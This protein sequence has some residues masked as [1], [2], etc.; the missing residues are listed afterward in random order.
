MAILAKGALMLFSNNAFSNDNDNMSGNLFSNELFP[1]TLPSKQM[2]ETHNTIQAKTT[3]E[4]SSHTIHDAFVELYSEDINFIMR[5]LHSRGS[6]WLISSNFNAISI[7]TKLA[8]DILMKYRYPHVDP[9]Y[10]QQCL[11]NNLHR[12]FLIINEQNDILIH[13]VRSVKEFL[14]KKSA[15][16]SMKVIVINNAETL[17]QSASS[18]IL[19]S[20]EDILG[21]VTIILL[22]KNQYEIPDTIRSR[23][24]KLSL[25][26]PQYD[27]ALA[28]CRK[29]NMFSSCTPDNTKM[30]L[31]SVQLCLESAFT[32]NSNQS[33]IAAM[34]NLFLFLHNPQS[35]EMKLVVDE[36]IKN[37]IPFDY[38]SNI[39]QYYCSLKYIRD[40]SFSYESITQLWNNIHVNILK[41]SEF[42]LDLKMK[43]IWLLSRFLA[44]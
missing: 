29:Y 42:K 8:H 31:I 39:V 6:S 25:Q 21:S 24:L 28:I 3:N 17:T 22:T 13:K 9:Q 16:S 10:V 43:I 14:Q 26:P 5:N 40:I 44:L 23:C 41:S 7:A 34:Q 32:L 30:L 38:I 20:I 15:D 35:I 36:L 19:K 37:D 18:A 11:K 33:S 2:A 27:N 1:E 12:D 4:K